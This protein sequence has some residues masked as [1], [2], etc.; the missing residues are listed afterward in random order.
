MVPKSKFDAAQAQNR[1]LSERSKAQLAEIENLRVHSRKIE[2]EL[3]LAEGDLSQLAEKFGVSRQMLANLGN[4]RQLLRDDLAYLTDRAMRA[5]AGLRGR[6][7]ELAARY[8]TLHY[9]PQTGIAKLDTDVL[10]DSG[11]D[12]LKPGADQ[13]IRDLAALLNSP[14]AADLKVMVVGHTDD[15][16][17]AG[18]ETRHR[19]PNNWYLSTA[20]AIAVSDQL[21]KD[22]ISGERLGVA[23]FGQNQPIH[24]NSTPLARQENR[25]VEIF[26]VSPDVPVVGM[27]ETLTNL[28]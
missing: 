13:F 21:Q 17:I 16:R 4:E 26:L 22:G 9:D 20:R 24:P 19:F 23:G 6:L 3:M 12:M 2:D 1:A 10:F 5:P 28:Y 8:P 25:R 14:E 18:R 11:E 7:A 27:T 15:Q